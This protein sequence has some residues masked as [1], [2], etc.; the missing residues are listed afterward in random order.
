MSPDGVALAYRVSLRT[1]AWKSGDRPKLEMH[2]LEGDPKF[3]V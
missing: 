3:S 2:V 1:A